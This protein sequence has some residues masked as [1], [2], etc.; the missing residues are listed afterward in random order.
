MKRHLIGLFLTAFLLI[1]AGLVLIWDASVLLAQPLSLSQP[2]EIQVKP[3]SRLRDAVRSLKS[4]G[5]FNRSRQPI[6]L[7]VW[8]RASGDAARIKA[9]E[10]RFEP[11]D[12]A[13]DVLRMM[14]EGDVVL[15]E[16]RV[17]EGQRFR[18]FLD[19]LAR[20]PEIEQTLDPLNAT[21]VMRALGQ[22]GLHPEGQFFPDTYRFPRGTRDIDLLRQAFSA[23]ARVLE[24]E[25]ANKSEDL[26]IRTPE[27]ALILAS[28]I[29]KETGLASERETI[30]GVFSRRLRK[31]MLLQTDPTVIYGMGDAFDGDIRRRDL[32]TDTP[33][34]TYTRAGLPPTPIC[35]PGRASIRAAL[36]PADGDSLYFVSRGDGSHY[37]SATL[38]EHE[39]AVRKYQLGQRSRATP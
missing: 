9:G 14:V 15:H 11:G 6:Y 1:A 37:F 29:E 34:N 39:Q 5:A 31:G 2:Q 3:G 26:K 12:T 33:Y 18:D 10:Y 38:A 35:L 21:S 7:E 30:S 8:A 25:W 24:E 27:E 16:L 32:R 4:A 23:M 22:E 17:V 20:H 13:S 28:I 19:K 36:H